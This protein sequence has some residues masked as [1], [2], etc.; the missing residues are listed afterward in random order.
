[1]SV[2]PRIS[3]PGKAL[4]RHVAIELQPPAPLPLPGVGELAHADDAG[5]APGITP[6]QRAGKACGEELDGGG[7]DERHIEVG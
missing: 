7:G 5:L 4:E 1:M 2:E 3:G 6:D